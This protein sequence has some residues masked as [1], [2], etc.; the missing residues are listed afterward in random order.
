M[1]GMKKRE[2]FTTRA[3]ALG[4]VFSALSVVFLS[5]GIFFPTFDLVAALV[6]SYPIIITVCELGRSY[7]FGVFMSSALLGIIISPQNSAAIFYL[8]FIGYYPILK[9]VIE[10]RIHRKLLAILLKI[11]WRCAE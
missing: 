11:F 10:V 8:A 6:A 7:A 9:S 2:K 5:F 1:L 4:A 3:I